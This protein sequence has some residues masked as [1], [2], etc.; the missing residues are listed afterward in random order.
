[1]ANLNNLS[2]TSKGKKKRLGQ[3]LGSGKGKT[4]GRGTK[5][6]KSR[7]KIPLSQGLAGVQFVRRLPLFRGKGRNKR[8]NSKPLIINLKDLESVP[9]NTVV[10]V[11][12]LFEKRF[13][14]KDLA[15]VYGVKLLGDGQVKVP[16][17]IN[18][19]TS[20]SAAKKIISAGGKV[21]SSKV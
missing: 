1:M 8:V 3:G 12:F 5:G 9:K 10:D 2:K 13:V 16:L 6:Q 18:I 14:K 17:Q 7:G 20:K 4:G 11:N 21:L 15:L 19:P